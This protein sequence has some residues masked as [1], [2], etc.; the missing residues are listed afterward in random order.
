MILRSAPI[1]VIVE[2]LIDAQT[3]FPQCS[4]RRDVWAVTSRFG[5]FEIA[6]LRMADSAKAASVL[7]LTGCC[8]RL[9]L[10]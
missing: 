9:T 2:L 7:L 10:I 8:D 6:P 5:R 4:A 3:V 1:P